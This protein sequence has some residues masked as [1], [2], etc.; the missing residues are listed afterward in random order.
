MRKMMMVDGR[1][2]VKEQLLYYIA[3]CPI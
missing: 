3:G 1:W 2:R